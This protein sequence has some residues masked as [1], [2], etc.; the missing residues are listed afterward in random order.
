M[1]DLQPHEKRIEILFKY[2]DQ[3]SITALPPRGTLANK[4]NEL[5][6]YKGNPDKK[7]S[8]YS[9]AGYG[10]IYYLRC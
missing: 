8:L 3:K 9:A 7:N 2:L 6:T 10:T 4:L 1:P 5:A